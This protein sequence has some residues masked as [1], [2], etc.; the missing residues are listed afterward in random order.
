MSAEDNHNVFDHTLA[1]AAYH[2]GRVRI[3]PDEELGR[4]RLQMEV[5]FP[6]EAVLDAPIGCHHVCVYTSS[7][8]AS[9]VDERIR[10][11]R[12]EVEHLPNF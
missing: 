6:H 9:V 10:E 7:A 2:A 1:H 3:V 5:L 4:A 8:P 12:C 11:H